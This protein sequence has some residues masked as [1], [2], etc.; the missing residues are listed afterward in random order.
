VIVLDASVLIAHF[1]STD[2][3]HDRAEQLLIDVVDEDLGASP[4]TL[5]EFLVGPAR[6]D[7]LNAAQSGLR[8]LEVVT[9]AITEDA[10]RRLALLRVGT[11]LRLPDCCVLLAAQTA[12][13][14][15][16]TFD[17]RL[18]NCAVDLGLL[19]VS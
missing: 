5:A 19:V 9:V 10:P 7:Q 15:I 16:A 14:S 6:A 11:G 8:E 12:G 2:G 17:D 4:L 1:E 18:A 13:A 3:H